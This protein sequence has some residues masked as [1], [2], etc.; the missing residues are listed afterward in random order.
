M[1]DHDPFVSESVCPTWAVP[2]TVGVETTD[3]ATSGSATTAVGS[4]VPTVD[5]AVFVAV[6]MP[7]IR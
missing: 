4:L 2:E 7:R 5:P 6:T 3:G 1:P